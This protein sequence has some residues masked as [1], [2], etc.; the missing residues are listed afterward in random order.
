MIPAVPAVVSPAMVTVPLLTQFS[1]TETSSVAPASQTI[2]AP[3]PVAVTATLL[4][5]F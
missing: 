2:P 5:Q 4:T 1:I 3:F